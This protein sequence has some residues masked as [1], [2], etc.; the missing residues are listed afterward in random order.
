MY[1]NRLNCKSFENIN[2]HGDSISWFPQ[3]FQGFFT[4]TRSRKVFLNLRM[5]VMIFFCKA[6]YCQPKWNIK[7]SSLYSKLNKVLIYLSCINNALSE[8]VKNKVVNIFSLMQIFSWTL[9]IPQP[10]YW[11]IKHLH[12]WKIIIL[13]YLMLDEPFIERNLLISSVGSRGYLHWFRPSTCWW[14]AGP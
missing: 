5:R 12:K 3:T 10:L 7:D 9:N 8:S 1:N 4:F 11:N 14:R 13:L 2:L 6:S